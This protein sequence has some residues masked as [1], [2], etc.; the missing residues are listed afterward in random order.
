MTTLYE[1][2]LSMV[3]WKFIKIMIAPLLKNAALAAASCL[4]AWS[5]SSS[6]KAAAIVDLNSRI[7]VE[8]FFDAALGPNGYVA[9]SDFNPP[10]FSKTFGFGQ[11]NLSSAN[12]TKDLG[13]FDPN[14]NFQTLSETVLDFDLLWTG[15]NFGVGFGSGYAE[16][17]FTINLA[18]PGN[19]VFVFNPAI[20]IDVSSDPLS[21]TF[22]SFEYDVRWN[23]QLINNFADNIFL[24]SVGGVCQTIACAYV[25]NQNFQI[26]LPGIVGKNTFYIDPTF[27]SGQAVPGPLPIL[28]AAAA[29]RSA[30][31]LRKLS[32]ALK[33]R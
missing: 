24:L 15:P 26:A 2:L 14:G 6:A 23:G 10:S 28:G 16:T 29:F 30:R 27:D 9:F 25:N 20:N 19:V 12:S 31:K 22:A 11:I 21:S 8:A 1:I 32:S 3:G 4:L 13:F 33:Q 7:T 17:G 18:N 5:F